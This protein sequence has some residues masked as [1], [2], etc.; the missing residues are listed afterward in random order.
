M[1]RTKLLLMASLL[2]SSYMQAGI[3]FVDKDASNPGGLNVGL[4]WQEAF[5]DIQSALDF[6]LPGDELWIAD[7]TYYPTKE[8][9]VD[10]TGTSDAR[11][12]A[13]HIKDD[14]KIYGGFNGT[15]SVL[16]DRKLTE[17]FTI[18]SGD[19]GVLN[20]NSDNAYHVIYTEDVSSKT[21]INGVVIS[22]GNANVLGGNN[23]NFHGGGWFNLATLNNQSN[24]KCEHVVF[25]D[26]VAAGSGGAV[27]NYAQNMGSISAEYL[28][29][30]FSNNS[31][32]NGGGIWNTAY[33]GGVFSITVTNTLFIDNAGSTS[34]GAIHNDGRQNGQ[35]SCTV[36]NCTF[37]GNTSSQGAGI[38]SDA[39]SNGSANTEVNNSIFWGNTGA[40]GDSFFNNAGAIATVDYTILSE[41]VAGTGV[42]TGS[43]VQFNV[44]PL[45][46]DAANGDYTLENLSPAIDAGN[47]AKNSTLKD[48]IGEDRKLGAAIDLGAYEI[49]VCFETSETISVSKCNDYTSPSGEFEWDSTGVYQDTIENWAGCDSVLTINL[50]IKRDTIKITQTGAYLVT[51]T[52][53]TNYVWMDCDNG[54]SVIQGADTSF[55]MP[56]INGDYAVEM[57]SKQGCRVQADCFT[58]SDVALN[59]ITAFTNLNVYPNP[60]NGLFT[61]DL[62]EANADASVITRDVFGKVVATETSVNDKVLQVAITGVQGVYFVEVINSEGGRNVVSIVK[63]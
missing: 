26:N 63:K 43:K 51:D 47:D 58:I 54:N 33:N 49:Y 40:N 45:F 30:E 5:T 22:N 52:S 24:P 27:T 9:D 23:L 53:G 17:N 21:V 19:V 10:G 2:V 29:C 4:D 42:N 41:T 59:E 57:R 61:V 6:A 20:D 15:E 38:Y 44:D 7:G 16:E 18:L 3:I 50:T 60:T 12:V 46:V 36:N 39:N 62:G 55:F 13:F 31:S 32:T 8:V 28:N 1:K 11:E 56:N 48:I 14:I 34:G 35:G 25:R 37:S